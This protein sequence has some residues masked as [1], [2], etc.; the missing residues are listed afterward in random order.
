[1]LLESNTA[2]VCI[3]GFAISLFSLS[4]S[5]NRHLFLS[6]LY[7]IGIA[8]IVVSF[9]EFRELRKPITT[10]VALQLQIADTFDS[11]PSWNEPMILGVFSA[12]L[13][14]ISFSLRSKF[15]IPMAILFSLAWVSLGVCASAE[16]NGLSSVATNRIQLTIPGSLL[17]AIGSLVY[18]YCQNGLS[19]LLASCGGILFT[20]GASQ[21]V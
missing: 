16:T 14:C 6:I 4:L 5:T 17:V 11:Q 15:E 7:I 2:E 21:V 19:V 13:V 1:M 20:V 9:S 8:I 18:F 10:N 3:S 12:I